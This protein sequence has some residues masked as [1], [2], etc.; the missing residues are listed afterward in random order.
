VVTDLGRPEGT[1]DFEARDINNRSQV[2]GNSSEGAVLW[3]HGTFVELP[4][5]AGGVP[6]GSSAFAINDRG[7]IVGS[8]DITTP[9]GQSTHAVLWTR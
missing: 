2:V 6:T 5:P 3:Q 8:A 4:L 1:T 9:D 7:Q